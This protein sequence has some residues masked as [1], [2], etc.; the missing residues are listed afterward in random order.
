MMDESKSNL[1][2]C[3]KAEFIL[4]YPLIS[5]LSKFVLIG[6]RMMLPCSMLPGTVFP[7]LLVFNAR[8]ISEVGITLPVAADGQLRHNKH[9]SNH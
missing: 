9:N 7:P 6:M 3:G 8:S 2:N 1:N 4:N 5:S